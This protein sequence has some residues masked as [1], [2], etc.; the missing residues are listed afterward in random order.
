MHGSPH[1]DPT[2]HG[3][4]VEKFSQLSGLRLRPVTAIT[5]EKVNSRFHSQ[6]DVTSGCFE[7][8]TL[9]V[10]SILKDSSLIRVG[11]PRLV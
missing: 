11:L 5:G 8:K 1:Q 6:S 10:P 2:S 3:G 7:V 4:T 9:E